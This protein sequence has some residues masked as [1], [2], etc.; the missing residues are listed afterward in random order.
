MSGGFPG[1]SDGKE[2]SC[3]AGNLGLISELGRS[4][5]E[6]NG[7]PLQYSCLENPM[8]RGACQA[9]IHG[10]A[11]SQTGLG[12]HTHFPGGS[13]GKEFA[14]NA[15]DLGSIPGLGRSPGQTT[16]ERL[17]SPVFWPGEFHGLSLGLQRVGHDWAIFTSLSPQGQELQVSCSPL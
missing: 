7:N 17:S 14:C 6:G 3:N 13:A 2:S 4:P 10:V 15:G 1:G 8:D 5:G 12:T 16:R 11:K 9:T